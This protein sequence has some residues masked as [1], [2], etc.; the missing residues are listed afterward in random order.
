[1]ST[2]NE[3]AQIHR[4][5]MAFMQP[6]FKAATGRQ[7][8]EAAKSQI[9]GL[10]SEAAIATFL[11]AVQAQIIALS[12]QDN[13]TRLKIATNSL[14]F[15]GVLLDVI[16]A[17]LA[18]LASTVLQRHIAVV[19]Q[20][21]GAIENASVE[22]LRE[23]MDQCVLLAPDVHRRVFVKVQARMDVIKK[24]LG[25]VDA[26]GQLNFRTASA[27]LHFEAVPEAIKHMQS[28]APIGDAAGTAMLFGI[29]CFFASVVCLAVSTQPVVVWIVSAATCSL[30]VLLPVVNRLLGRVGIR[31]PT[32]FDI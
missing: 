7:D 17:C 22:Q 4:F 12:Y 25:S 14:G 9:G 32:V 29:L 30:V 13:S 6:V 31:L 8:W 19:E 10:T 3:V 20:Q 27:G 16:T 24:Q 5:A 23:I 28:V 11:A 18:L 1:M 21:L 15:A 26:E 2:S